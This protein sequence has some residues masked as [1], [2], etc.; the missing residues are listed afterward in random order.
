MPKPARL[1]AVATA[2]PPDEPS[3][4]FDGLNAFHTMP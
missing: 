3:D 2:E 1:A 4:V